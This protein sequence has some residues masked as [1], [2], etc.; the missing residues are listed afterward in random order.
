MKTSPM[1]A[2]HYYRIRLIIMI[3]CMIINVE[4]EGDSESDKKNLFSYL[5]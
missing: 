4:N 5:E 3:F 1:H 2:N